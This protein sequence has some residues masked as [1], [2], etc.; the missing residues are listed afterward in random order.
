MKFFGL[1]ILGFMFG[2]DTAGTNRCRKA[3][4]K[5]VKDKDYEGLSELMGATID[6][7]QKAVDAINEVLV[8]QAAEHGVSV[9]EMVDSLFVGNKTT[10]VDKA[11][12]AE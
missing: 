1:M 3:L 10:R 5:A 6:T 11:P 12:R 9:E 7:S 2:L 8:R 4:L